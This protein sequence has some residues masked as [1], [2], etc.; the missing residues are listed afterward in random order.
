MTTF[1]DILY[2]KYLST[3]ITMHEPIF[4]SKAYL[5]TSTHFYNSLTEFKSSPNSL[6]H[7]LGS[8]FIYKY[9]HTESTHNQEK[10]N[11]LKSVLDNPFITDT[12]KN[13]FLSIFQDIQC[14]YNT[15]CKFAFKYKWKKSKYANNHDLIMNPININQYFVCTLMHYN[16]KYMFTKSDLTK[17][18]ENS[19]I[20][21]PYIFAEPLPIKNPYNNNM[22]DKSHL[23]TIYFFMKHGGFMLPSIFHQYFLH[24]FHLK[25]FR[26]YTECMIREMHIKT[27]LTSNSKKKTIFNIKTMIQLYNNQCTTANMYINIDD[28]FPEDVLILAMKPYLH[29]FYTSNYTLCMSTKSFSNC[30]LVYRLKTFKK[31]SPGFG[32]KQVKLI[33]K[34]NFTNKKNKP[35]YITEYTPYIEKPY[36]KNY[37]TSH[38]EIIEDYNDEKD[39]SI[40]IHSF[41]ISSRENDIVNNMNLSN[42][43]A[44]MSI[45]NEMTDNDDAEFDDTYDD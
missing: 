42:M 2:Q 11:Y 19:L 22:F 5:N 27:M 28:S 36:Y 38:I 1:C 21:S 7:I 30:E 3:T 45:D 34:Y 17:I 20:H 43:F 10:F 15:F 31:N 25:L 4:L 41:N 32:R 8:T 39:Y 29:L 23:Y 40:P 16:T 18:I 35:E 26:D 44:N 14:I 12:Q 24:N 6:M 9:M 13:D 33:T 37:N